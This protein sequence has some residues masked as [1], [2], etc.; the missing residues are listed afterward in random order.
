MNW[1]TEFL[2]VEHASG[3]SLIYV[4]HGWDDHGE[5]GRRP[6]EKQCCV[7]Q[8]L[9]HVVSAWQSCARAQ[10]HSTHLED[11]MQLLE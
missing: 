11:V 7:L 4:I 1:G 8:N 9:C 2:L 5:I 3:E 6:R 10:L